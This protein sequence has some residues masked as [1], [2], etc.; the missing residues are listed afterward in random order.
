M[1]FRKKPV[2]IEAMQ[3]LSSDASILQ[4]LQ[5][6]GQRV[7]VETQADHDRFATYCD[8]VKEEGLKI[9]TLEG[10]MTATVGDWI[11]KGVSGE[12]YPCKPDIFDKTYEPVEDDAG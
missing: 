12:F 4:C 11:I 8:A 2:V 1:K 5:F 7:N 9:E 10:T 6:M 3:L